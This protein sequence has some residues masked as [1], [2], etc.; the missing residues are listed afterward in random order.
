LTGGSEGRWLTCPR[1]LAS[2][3]N[4]S[5]E[6]EPVP[7]A[8]EVSA[9]VAA[10]RECPSCGRPTET[11]WRFCPFCE[12]PLRRSS[13]TRPQQRPRPDDDAV[14]D[15]RGVNVGLLILGILLVV[16]VLLF[17]FTGGAGLILEQRDIRGV[18][19]IGG[20]LLAF[21]VGGLM[22]IAASNR[23]QTFTAA[24]GVLTYFAA[25]IG[26]FCL[27]VLTLC[28]GVLNTCLQKLH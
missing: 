1:C 4:P 11:G 17:S 15:D 26:A 24:T 8:A 21:L 2:I 10:P 18:L 5:Y 12:H 25:G 14:R 9:E 6:A 19:L 22:V 3:H 13:S 20:T 23:N 27:L 28:I 16:G 7:L